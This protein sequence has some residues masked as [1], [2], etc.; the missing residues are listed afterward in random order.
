MAIGPIAMVFVA[1]AIGISSYAINRRVEGVAL[2]A[3]AHTVVL[4]VFGDGVVTVDKCETVSKI[5]LID[6]DGRVLSTGDVV[7]MPPY[8]CKFRFTLGDK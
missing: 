3:D 5:Q 8:L 4:P 7:I 2:A 1:V 6:S